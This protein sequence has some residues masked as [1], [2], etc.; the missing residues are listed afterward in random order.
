[1]KIAIK[2]LFLGGYNCFSFYSKKFPSAGCLSLFYTDKAYHIFKN[3]K[4][5]AKVVLARAKLD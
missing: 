1:M 5:T 3:A 2:V 4:T